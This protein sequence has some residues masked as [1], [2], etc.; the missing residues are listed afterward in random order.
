MRTVVDTQDYLQGLNSCA[1]L[2][3]ASWG[4]SQLWQC[5]LLTDRSAE[6]QLNHTA[7]SGLLDQQC[8]ARFISPIWGWA[9]FWGDAVAVHLSEPCSTRQTCC[10]L[11]SN[12]QGCFFCLTLKRRRNLKISKRWHT[13]AF[14]LPPLFPVFPSRGLSSL[15]P[16]PGS[17]LCL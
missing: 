8:L 7:T 17:T 16:S 15:P 2:L 3:A 12:M 4:C 5:L 9:V 10:F 6:K 13:F 14:A 11:N 1:G